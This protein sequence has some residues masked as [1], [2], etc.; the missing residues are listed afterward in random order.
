MS[1]DLA[2]AILT[3]DLAA[4]RENYRILKQQIGGI[5][6]AAAVKGDAYGIGAVEASQAMARDGC[7]DF[8]VVSVS[9]GMELRPILGDAAIHVLYGPMAGTEATLV[10][11][12]LIPVLNSLGDVERWAAEAARRGRRLPCDLHFDTGMNRTGFPASEAATL[13]DE[14]SRLD[15]LNIGIVMSHLH[16]A[17]VANTAHSDAQLARFKDIRQ[18][19]P[20]G[21]A[22]FANSSGIFLGPAFHFDLGRPGIALYG[23]NPLSNAANPMRG[24]IRLQGRIIQT[25]NLAAGDVVG[26]AA[27]FR[28]DGPMRVATV[29]VGYADGYLRA[30][31]GRGVTHIDGIPCPVLGR[32]SM[33]LIT[34]D[35]TAVPEDKTLPGAWVDIIGPDQDIEDI[36][37]LAGTN[38]NEILT[39]LGDRYHRVY[40]GGD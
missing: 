19:F 9:E 35:V 6:C 31:A 25:R 21:R 10:E 7:T 27:T 15:G 20:M 29:P 24:V 16:S 22:S 12:D 3:V 40:V 26:Y 13:A 39:S 38:S 34:I 8:F 17:D 1:I 11:H 2:A 33:D 36:A 32:I 14:P 4:V 18:H 37:V 28:A 30:L 23:G 5:P